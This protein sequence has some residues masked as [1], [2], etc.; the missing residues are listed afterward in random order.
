MR[1]TNSF[2]A[3]LL[4]TAIF[5]P[6]SPVVAQSLFV[7]PVAQ[8]QLQAADAGPGFIM[9][10]PLPQSPEQAEARQ[11][12]VTPV[13]ASS[14]PALTEAQTLRTGGGTG[15]AAP[16]SIPE[17]ARALKKRRRPDL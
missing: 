10:M 6:T 5:I 9:G 8:T 16:V 12:N 17:L 7:P 2:R 1:S 11:R 4:A 15:A 14:L 3:A 13:R